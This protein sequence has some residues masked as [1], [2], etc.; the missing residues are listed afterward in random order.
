MQWRLDDVVENTGKC[1]HHAG[2]L[3][4]DE[5][6]TFHPMTLHAQYL[7]YF[8]QLFKNVSQD[9]K[10]CKIFSCNKI[11]PM[12]KLLDCEL[13]RFRSIIQRVSLNIAPLLRFALS[14]RGLGKW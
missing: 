4:I 9:D 2:S 14:R 1:E 12:V 10:E 11:R 5:H 13:E 8:I 6:A 3:S 7:L